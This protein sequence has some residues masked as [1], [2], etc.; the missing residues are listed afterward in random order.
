MPLEQ[1]HI[2]D[3][4]AS[5]EKTGAVVLVMTESRAWDGSDLRLF[6]LQEKIN[7]YLSFALDGEMAASCPQ[8]AGRP[9]R[10]QL[11]CAAPLD[12]RTLHFI[13]VVRGQ[14]AFQDIGFEVRVTGA[15]SQSAESTTCGS[16]DCGC[17]HGA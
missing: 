7:A 1:A 3:I 5:D 11:D 16:G 10:L 17:V 15:V 9:L 13:Q 2:I 12:A 8:F 4:I 14:I 6:E